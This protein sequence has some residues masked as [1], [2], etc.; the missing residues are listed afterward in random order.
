[1]PH[2]RSARAEPQPSLICRE[3][4]SIIMAIWQIILSAKMRLFSEVVD[5]DGAAVV[6][7][8]ADEYSLAGD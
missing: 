1:M 4:T 8:D 7:A 3:I 6:W 5:A 2:G